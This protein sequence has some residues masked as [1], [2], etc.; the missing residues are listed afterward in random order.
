MPKTPQTWQ[1]L[2]WKNRH[3]R[4]E[5]IEFDEPTHKYT[6]DGANT[7]WISCTGFIHDFFPHFDPKAALRAIKRGKNYTTSKYYGKT[8]QEILD[9]W[10]NS[11]KEASG[12]GTAMHLAIEQFMNASHDII[13]N[14][15]KQTKEWKY[16]TNFWADCGPDLVPYRMEWEV[17]SLEHKLAGSIDAIFYRPSDG[18]YVIYDWKRS[19][20][21]K[22]ENDY[23]NGLGPLSHLPASN[24][25]Q[26][27]IQ[28]NLY[29]WILENHYGLSI[30]G[31]YLI[32]L[33][34]DN[35]T[36][37]R[38]PLNRLDDEINDILEARRAGLERGQPLFVAPPE[39]ENPIS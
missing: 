37:R 12:L 1:T 4:D 24:Y 28:L 27:T 22:M 9:G 17:F 3:P 21:I 10:S 39:G 13:D 25:W 34:P 33:H 35:K 38:Y 19:K 36:Y 2:A 18:K 15:V 30:E 31:M 16:F 5:R 32:V 26:Y 23:E 29:R 20:Q 7:K 14:S 11:G 8:D 6:I